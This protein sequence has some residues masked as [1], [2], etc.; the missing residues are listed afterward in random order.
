MKIIP[1]NT[2]NKTANF[3]LN[4]FV[5]VDDEDYEYL[6]NWYWY[7]SKSKKLLYATT[8]IISDGKRKTLKMHRLIMK[9]P[10]GLCVDHIDHDTLNNQKTN[11]RICTQR[12]NMWNFSS[13]ANNKTSKY[14]GVCYSKNHGKWI[15]S[16]SIDNKSKHLGIF[17]TEYDAAIAYDKAVKEYRKEFAN[18]NFK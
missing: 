13:M 16:M 9:V 14:L 18:T 1:L 8:N 6:N 12:E 11:L 4:L 15:A 10:S 7:A 5:K 17:D 3:K 2:K